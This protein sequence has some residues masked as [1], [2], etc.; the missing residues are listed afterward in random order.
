MALFDNNNNNNKM[1]PETADFTPVPPPGVL[2]QTT[3]SETRLNAST[4]AR[5]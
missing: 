5:V 3:L 1:Q 4:G 2:D